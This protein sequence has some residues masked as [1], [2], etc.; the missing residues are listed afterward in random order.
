M[1]R[2]VLR[3]WNERRKLGRGRCEECGAVLRDDHKPRNGWRACSD[4][5]Y[6][7]LWAHNLG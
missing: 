1:M 2:D 4:E 3:R 6:A 7:K 5:C